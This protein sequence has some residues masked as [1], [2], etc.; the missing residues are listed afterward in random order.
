MT[1]DRSDPAF[2]L[3]LRIIVGLQLIEWWRISIQPVGR[4][5]KDMAGVG[6]GDNAF[7]LALLARL[8][9]GPR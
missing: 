5:L 3:G 9:S 1:D 8:G 6:P 2:G 4:A 7:V